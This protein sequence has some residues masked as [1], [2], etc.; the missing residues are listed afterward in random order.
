MSIHRTFR[1]SSPLILSLLY[2]LASTACSA[3]ADESADGQS[4]QPSVGKTT[5]P[6]NPS[7]P[8]D[9][10]HGHALVTK[11]AV[12]FLKSR[13]LLPPELTDANLDLVLYG[14]D[15]ADHPWNGRPE[16]PKVAA[17]NHM[18]KRLPSIGVSNIHLFLPRPVASSSGYFSYNF[19]DAVGPFDGFMT[20]KASGQLTWWPSSSDNASVYLRNKFTVS[21]DATAL[22]LSKSDGKEY[23][24]AADNMFH[25]TLGDVKDFGDTQI[26]SSEAA[27]RLYPLDTPDVYEDFSRNGSAA[28]EFVARGRNQ[29]LLAN[30]DFGVTKY[31][32]VLYQLARKFMNDSRAE[33]DLAELIKA[34]NDVWG[35]HTGGMQGHGVLDGMSYSFSHTYLGGMPYICAGGSDTDPCAAGTP[36]WPVWVPS[37]LP[38]TVSADNSEILRPLEQARPGRSTR[39]GLIYL[40]WATHMIQDAS[41]PHHAANWAGPQHEAQDNIG[42]YPYYYDKAPSNLY[43]PQVMLDPHFS[44]GPGTPTVCPQPAS[45]FWMDTYMA[46]DVDALLGPVN[47]HKSVSEICRS[48]G[49]AESEVVAGSLNWS[50]VQS[51]FLDHAKTAYYSR[52]EHADIVDGAA[53]I[54]NAILG[55]IKLLLCAFPNGSSATQG[56]GDADRNGL[57]DVLLTSGAGWRSIPV[58]FSNGDGT[59]GVANSVVDDFPYYAAEPGA[60]PVAGDFNGDGRADVALTGGANWGSIPVAFSRG[61]SSFGVTNLGV[62]DFPFYAQENGAKPVAGDFNG[63]GRADIA[64][65]GG[66]NWGTIPVAFSNGDGTFR[67]TNINV[68]DFPWFAQSAAKPV[69][70]D[71]NG[72]GRADIALTGGADWRTIPVAFSNGDGTFDVTNFGVADFPLYAQQSGA[73]PVAGDFNGDGRGDIALTGGVGWRSLVVAFSNGDGTFSVT[74]VGV[75]DFPSFAQQSGARPVAG[76]FNGDGRGDIALT[77]GAGWR[78]LPVAFSNGDGSFSVRN[79]PLDDF[80]GY[81]QEAGATPVGSL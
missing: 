9:K 46:A 12:Q 6:L 11:Q 25:Y 39:A 76:D 62:A 28:D 13:D 8:S 53:Y 65:T 58:A 64:L 7:L 60:K 59:F 52:K 48:V 26:S 16:S 18:T 71:F 38:T 34:G 20:V 78:S 81:A 17:V 27:M 66:A 47:G 30:A 61:D 69:A 22:G 68:G 21:L 49:L 80:P 43:Y 2:C 5:A 67:V 37:E 70:G 72:D 50:S 36:V 54:K 44:C 29:A 15:F 75:D 4:A 10:A 32:A 24:Y 55:T 51:V 3:D 56:R 35:W 74:N 40:G 33:P 57:S 73:K 23:E 41:T 45:N 1:S 63:D 14:N 31:G 42:D 79:E 19:S 77:G